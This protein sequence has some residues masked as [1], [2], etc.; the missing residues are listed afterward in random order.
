MSK[1]F[2]SLAKR[3]CGKFFPSACVPEGRLVFCPLIFPY[4]VSPYGAGLHRDFSS[5]APA[6]IVADEVVVG[7]ACLEVHQ[8]GNGGF[9]GAVEAAQYARRLELVSGVIASHLHAATHTL[10]DVDDGDAP[11][12][13][14]AK[15]P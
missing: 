2:K 10:A 6:H 9:H 5:D 14:L 15:Q 12:R 8:L 1:V 7:V 13:G 11:C 4:V 3:L